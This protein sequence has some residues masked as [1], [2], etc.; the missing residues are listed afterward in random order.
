MLAAPKSSDRIRTALRTT[1][2]SEINVE[3]L[4]ESLVV[5]LEVGLQ[6]PSGGRVHLLPVGACVS[7]LLKVRRFRLPVWQVE[8]GQDDLQCLD[9]ALEEVLALEYQHLLFAKDLEPAQEL[10]H[11]DAPGHI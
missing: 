1:L 8:E 2:P 10:I 5:R 7:S 3:A 4:V 6:P 11:V 9:G